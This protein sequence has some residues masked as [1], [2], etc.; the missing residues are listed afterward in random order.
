[1]QPGFH[2]AKR[3]SPILPINAQRNRARQLAALVD[4]QQ[5]HAGGLRQCARRIEEPGLCKDIGFGRVRGEIMP[6][7]VEQRFR[8]R[9]QLRG[10]RMRPAPDR[11]RFRHACHAPLI[12]ARG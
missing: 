5:L 10:G 4:R 9:T 1:M 2:M 6:C 11:H 8:Q 7:R 12:A 3:K